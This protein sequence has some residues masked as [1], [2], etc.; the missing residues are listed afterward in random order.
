MKK[1]I[2]YF[3][4]I[5]GTFLTASCFGLIVLPQNFAAGGV[6]GFS[7][8]FQNIIPLPLSTIVFIINMILFLIG[9]IFLG[10]DFIIKTFL[11]SIIFPVALEI[12]QQITVFHELSADPFLSSL[13]GGC[14]L[15][16]GSGLIL[17]GNGSGGGFDIVGLILHKKWGISVSVVMY[18]FD[19][20]VILTQTIENGILKTMYGVATILVSC[21]IV[22]IFLT[23]GRRASRIFI[24]SKNSELIR[25]ALLN[26]HDVGMTYL[27]GESGYLRE[28]VHVIMT[29]VYAEKV[30]NIKRTVYALDPAAFLFIDT[31]QYVGGRGYT[32]ER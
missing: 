11:S 5:L 15:G 27:H 9:W 21:I 24:L 10:K 12:T 28:Q 14:L 3:Y 23:R 25:E 22:N 7:L 17:I 1:I 2:L 18:V 13:L 20:F 16:I 19:F 4:V 30:E 8:L 32:I 26:K 6:T 31:I 29:V